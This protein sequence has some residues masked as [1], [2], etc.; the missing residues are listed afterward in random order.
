MV[1]LMIA[2]TTL[3]TKMIMVNPQ[4]MLNDETLK[5]SSNISL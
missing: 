4:T 1:A 3:T 5:E 2:V